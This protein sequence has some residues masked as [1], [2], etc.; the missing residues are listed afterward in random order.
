MNRDEGRSEVEV[1][2]VGSSQEMFEL[3]EIVVSKETP[4]PRPLSDEEIVT[5]LYESDAEN[6]PEVEDLVEDSTDE[7][8]Q[9][10]ANVESDS[11]KTEDEVAEPGPSS[12]INN[13]REGPTLGKKRTV[14][15]VSGPIQ[16]R[17]RRGERSGGSLPETV[18]KLL[19][20]D[21]ITEWTVAY[22]SVTTPGRIGQQNILKETWGPTP[23]TKWHVSDD[24]DSSA[25]RLLVDQSMLKRIKKCTEA[26]AQQLLGNDSCSLH[27][28][29]LDAF[30]ALSYVH[31]ALGARC[32][33]VD[34]LWS[35]KW[36][37]PF[38]T[39]TMSR[40]RFQEI[41][42]YLLFDEKNIHCWNI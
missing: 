1:K 37:A 33:E 19:G 12:N 27:L 36:G 4:R 24:N 6:D 20:K 8:Y 30:V 13:A 17:R 9:P 34:E 28:E 41:L 31:G 39:D 22:F 40:N 18:S 7:D 3:S 38:F 42:K 23:H 10:V 32:I 14:P 5:L 16:N 21:R 15:P 25:W 29:E 35:K 2:A 26:E 11:S